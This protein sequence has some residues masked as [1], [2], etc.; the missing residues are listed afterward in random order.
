VTQVARETC[1]HPNHA[2]NAWKACASTLEPA[3]LQQLGSCHFHELVYPLTNS[4][5]S[6]GI[7]YI[8][9]MTVGNANLSRLQLLR[10]HARRSPSRSIGFPPGARSRTMDDLRLPQRSAKLRLQQLTAFFPMLLPQ[11][12]SN[13]GPGRSRTAFT[14]LEMS[15]ALGIASLILIAVAQVSSYSARSFVALGKLCRP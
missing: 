8:G 1:V 7:M 2:R 9:K 5:E 15:V 3:R 4:G 10:Q 6:P 11:C 13:A 12:C 14:L